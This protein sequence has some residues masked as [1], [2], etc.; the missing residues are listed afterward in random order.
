MFEKE[1]NPNFYFDYEIDEE[2]KFIRCYWADAESIRSYRCFGDVVVFDTTYNTNKYSMIFS[3]F[4]GVNH[5]GQT[6]LFGCGIL[7]DETTE[8]FVW[9]LSKF[10]ESISNHAPPLIITD[11]DAAIAKAISLV[12]PLTFHRYCIWHILNKFS[13]KMNAMVYNEQFH[14]LVNIIKNS[15]TPIEFEERW[16]EAMVNT[17][18]H[19][20]EWLQSM[21]GIRGRWVPPYVKHIFSAGM[22]SSQRS[23]SGHAFFKKYVNRNNSLMGFITR[24]NRALSHQRH[25]EIVANH[26]DLNE[27]PRL[28]SSLMMEHQMVEIYTKKVFLLFQTEV[29]KS[30]VYICSKISNFVGGKTYIV[31]RYESGKYFDR[32]RELTYYTDDDYVSCSCRTFEFEGYPCRHIVCFFLKKQVLLLP[33]KYIIRRWTKNAKMGTV[34]EPSAT[35]NMDDSSIQSLMARHGLLSHKASM[36]VDNAAVTDARSTFLLNEFEMLN[37]KV[38]Q[39][40]N[41]GNVGKSKSSSKSR[42]VKQVIQ[43]PNPVRAKGCGKRLKSSKEKAIGKISRQ[44]SVCGAN[45]HDKRTCSRFIDRSHVPDVPE[46]QYDYG[47]HQDS[48]R[49]DDTFTS[50]AYSSTRDATNFTF[51]NDKNIYQYRVGHLSE[52]GSPQRTWFTVAKMVV[53]GSQN[54]GT[55]SGRVRFTV[56]GDRTVREVERGGRARGREMKHSVGFQ[57]WEG[58][59]RDRHSHEGEMKEEIPV[60]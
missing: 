58:G 3:P 48:W 30:N 21:Y 9:L 16:N 31:R 28:M 50:L 22:S 17:G 24:F 44:C 15:E 6:I 26:V 35:S 57:Q 39:V 11:Q 1:K 27:Q 18:L 37:L 52:R 42:E 46:N 7:S 14:T 59:Q 12:M 51:E 8:S 53:H 20:N 2:N 45:G 60:D 47:G 25:E 40:D 5:H 19:D 32:P 54:G 36:L 29:D 23:E 4:V 56:G 43:D 33:D 49:E 10:M 41:G 13:E 34:C 38:D 55:V